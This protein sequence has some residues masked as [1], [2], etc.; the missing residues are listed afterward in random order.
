MNQRKI[1]KLQGV[2][3]TF[4]EQIQAGMYLLDIGI[5]LIYIYIQKAAATD[6]VTTALFLS[7]S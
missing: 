4:I 7:S 1:H 5:Q 3:S 6:E 2:N